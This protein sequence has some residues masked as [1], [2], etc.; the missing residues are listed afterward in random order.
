MRMMNKL[1]IGS[2]F[3]LEPKPGMCLW[4]TRK[5]ERQSSSLDVSMTTGVSSSKQ[6][7]KKLSSEFNM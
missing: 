1:T 7:L 4:D 6:R 5:T 2:E 3:C